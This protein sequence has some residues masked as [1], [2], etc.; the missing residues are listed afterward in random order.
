MTPPLNTCRL[1]E[2]QAYLRARGVTVSG[3]NKATLREIAIA[4]EQL[5]L[6]VDP[7]FRQ[8]S[9]YNDILCKLKKAG[10]PDTYPLKLD[11]YTSDFTHI[12]D[13]GLIDVLNYVIFNKSD[14]DGKKTER[15]QIL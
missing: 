14:Y 11:G 9:I 7:D 6:P 4:V 12:P 8:D 5:N 3:Y 10:L 2:L 15:L 1:P 13:F